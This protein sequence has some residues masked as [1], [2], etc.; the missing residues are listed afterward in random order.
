LWPY[1]S[2]SLSEDG[3]EIEIDVY[4]VSDPSC[5]E[6]DRVETEVSGN[7][8][9]VSLFYLGPPPGGFCNIPC[10]LGTDKLIVSLD[11][12]RDPGLSVVKNPDTRTHCSENF[13]GG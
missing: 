1:Q 13:A 5:W 12:P 7:D 2:A 8:L 11:V 4:R 10:P 9:V 6:F 3:S